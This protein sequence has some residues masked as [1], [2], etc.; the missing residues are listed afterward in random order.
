MYQPHFV[1]LSPDKTIS[2]VAKPYI[3]LAH[4]PRILIEYFEHFVPN[5]VPLFLNLKIT[6]QPFEPKPL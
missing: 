3:K 1:L 4:S 2:F 5:A 6:F